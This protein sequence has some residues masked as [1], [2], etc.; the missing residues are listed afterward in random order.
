MTSCVV[1]CPR[2]ASTWSLAPGK[3]PQCTSSCIEGGGVRPCQGRTKETRPRD[4][5]VL[6]VSNT[7]LLD[8]SLCGWLAALPGF[9][10]MAWG[11]F[12]FLL[13]FLYSHSLITVWQ[14]FMRYDF[15]INKI[16]QNPE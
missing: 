3:E 7:C 1:T 11:L 13:F 5:T 15:V 6:D 16:E 8:S 14:V 2:I 10:Y 4:L 9:E 12:F